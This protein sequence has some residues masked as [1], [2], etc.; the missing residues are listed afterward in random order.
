MRLGSPEIVFNKLNG[1]CM[2]RTV[3]TALSLALLVVSQAAMAEK[4]VTKVLE[5]KLSKLI[6]GEA[7]DSIMESPLKGIYQVSYG[8]QIFYLSADGNYL[9][10]GDL[11]DVNTRKNLT[12]EAS[13][14]GRASMMKKV[15]TDSTVTF[16]PKGETKHTITVFTD[17]DCPYCVKLH[18]EVE[19][20]NKAGIAVRY[21]LYPRAG[22]GSNSYK[23]AVSVWCSDD[24]KDALTKSKNREDVE[25]R[26][27][28]NPVKEHMALGEEIGVSGTPAIV[29]SDGSLIPGYRPAKDM[30]RLLDASSTN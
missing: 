8:A 26:S 16:A 27:C 12:V 15:K 1:N 22:I 9:L 7:P 28:D 23:K 18:D 20:Y 13:R 3:I 21:M 30:A 14:G 5:E 17:I 29:L 6:P 10:Q 4:D 2:N 19:D 11:V 24:R 25:S